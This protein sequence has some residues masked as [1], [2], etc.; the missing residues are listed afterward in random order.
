METPEFEDLG[1]H[2][3]VV[4]CKLFDFMPFS[5]DRCSQ[6]FCMQH[7]SYSKHLCPDA[8]HKDA[9]LLICPLCA[10][11][12]QLVPGQDPNI[13]WE[14][15]KKKCPVPDC[16]ET[17]TFSNMIRCRECAQ[18][19]CLKHRFAPDHM[20]AGPKK[21]DTSFPFKGLLRRSQKFDL[22]VSQTS[23]SSVS[24]QN[25]SKPSQWN[26][27]LLNAVSA[28]RASAEASIHRLSSM[29][30]QALQKA[31]DGISRS[32]NGAELVEQ[33]PQCLQRFS[34]I[35]ALIEHVE[36]YH[37]HESNAH[38]CPKYNTPVSSV[39]HME[40]NHGGTSMA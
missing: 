4:E 40:R 10:N 21:Q 22:V 30:T 26:S 18:D 7:R 31:K 15:H 3:S 39:E 27:G 33:C 23:S 36:R 37:D 1:K 20:C 25:S 24:N 12:V 28:V 8:H 32:G 13:T 2:C 6:A 16:I 14:S 9:T 17:L 29:T 34:S 11:G 19:H 5:C 35:S 38:A